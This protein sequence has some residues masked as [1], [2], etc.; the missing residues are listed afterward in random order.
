MF[1]VIETAPVVVKLLAK[2]GPYEPSSSTK[3][4]R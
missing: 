3:K 4:E 2:Y 1:V